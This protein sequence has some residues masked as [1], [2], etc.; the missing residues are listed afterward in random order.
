MRRKQ[1]KTIIGYYRGIPGMVR[2]LNSE[3][4]ELED[5][6]SGLRSTSLDGMPHSHTAGKPTEELVVRME[7]K[8]TRARIQEIDV[9]KQVLHMDAAIIRDCLDSLNSKYKNLVRMKYLNGYSW[10]KISV[11][12]GVPDGTIRR[13][14]DRAIERLGELLD[15]APMAEE[16]LRRALCA[17]I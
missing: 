3:R 10:A 12:L 1:V 17:R 14:N 15:E 8:N 11:S 13:W 2:L 6:Y 4:L 5:E 9:K 16:I 7:A